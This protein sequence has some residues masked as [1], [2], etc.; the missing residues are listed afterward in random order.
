MTPDAR[1]DVR[2]WKV[3]CRSNRGEADDQNALPTSV[4]SLGHLRADKTEQF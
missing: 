1:P 3:S 2:M 4:N